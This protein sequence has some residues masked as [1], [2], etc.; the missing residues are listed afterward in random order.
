VADGRRARRSR[1][2]G[3]VL[4]AL[5]VLLVAVNAAL[6]WFAWQATATEHARHDALAAGRS[7]AQR[8]LSYDYR[9][10]DADIAAAKKETTGAF[11]SEY[12]KTTSSVVKPAAL[13]YHVVVRADVRA[14]SVVS[15]TPKQVVLLLFVNQTTTSSRVT[16]PKLDQNRVRLTLDKSGDQWLVSKVDAL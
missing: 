9:H 7:H 11:R 12:A 16:G 5:V 10:I 13:Q 3:W 1:L 14:A 4:G 6:G 15:A 8:I 2:I